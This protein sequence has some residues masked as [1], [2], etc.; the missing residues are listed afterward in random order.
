MIL[1]PDF[2]LLDEPTSALDM[3]V[4]AQVVNLLSD[5]QLKYNL[6]Y[7]FI[8]HDLKVVKALADDVIVMRDGLVVEAGRANQI[9]NNPQKNYTKA[10]MAAAFDI[11]V[12][13]IENLKG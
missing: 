3:S 12:K 10:L 5:L 1:K 4:Q 7:I 9:F 13:N 2:V 6:A 11:S 8:S